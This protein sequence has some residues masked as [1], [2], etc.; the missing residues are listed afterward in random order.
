MVRVGVKVMLLCKIGLRFHEGG[1]RV[2]LKVVW[3]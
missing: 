3:G 2:Y 1:V